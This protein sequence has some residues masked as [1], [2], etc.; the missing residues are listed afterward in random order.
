MRYSKRRMDNL[1]LLKSMD[2]KEECGEVKLARRFR[3]F[4][5]GFIFFTAFVFAVLF[6]L[7]L[8]FLLRELS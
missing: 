6:G 5:V 4:R 1:R 2:Q 3:H 7:F 8:L